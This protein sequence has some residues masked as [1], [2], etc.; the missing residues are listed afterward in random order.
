MATSSSISVKPWRVCLCN[1]IPIGQYDSLLREPEPV[2]LLE[3]RDGIGHDVLP[4]DDDGIRRNRIPSGR[5]QRRSGFQLKTRGIR[6]PRQD[7]VRASPLDIQGQP[8]NRHALDIEIR[9]VRTARTPSGI[10]V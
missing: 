3:A 7:N 1:F 9:A 6:G 5:T 2:K 10:E 8:L 4:I